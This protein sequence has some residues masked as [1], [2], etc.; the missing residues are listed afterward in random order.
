MGKPE[1]CSIGGSC[2]GTRDAPLSGNG[3]GEKRAGSWQVWG[4]VHLKKAHCLAEL[5]QT[6]SH[7]IT[8]ESPTPGSA[9]AL[10]PS[11][12]L[13]WPFVS[14]SRGCPVLR[15]RGRLSCRQQAEPYGGASAE[16]AS[17]RRQW[18]F[19]WDR[20]PRTLQGAQGWVRTR[21][22]LSAHQPA[23]QASGSQQGDVG[24]TPSWGGG[25][26]LLR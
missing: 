4:R 20:A 8:R 10:H 15:P 19:P 18:L 22:L 26:W 12:H 5:S 13:S 2:E 11:A 6:V 14:G 1:R 17:F 24:Q 7:L 9:R 21:S 25:P 23:L 3:S 16:H